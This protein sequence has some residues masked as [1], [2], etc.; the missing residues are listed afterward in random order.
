M[1]IK[2]QI[3]NFHHIQK[4]ADISL[5][6]RYNNINVSRY[7]LFNHC[8]HRSIERLWWNCPRNLLSLA[9]LMIEHYASWRTCNTKLSA[10]CL[11]LLY[12]LSILTF[13]QTCLYLFSIYSLHLT[14]DLKNRSI[15][16]L[17]LSKQFFTKLVE[18]CFTRLL[19][20]TLRSL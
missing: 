1:K 8:C 5:F 3:P 9:C 11:L 13:R 6:L 14:C 19:C 16:N 18:A 7:L 2:K 17:S 10:K 12:L 20:Y 4:E 15:I